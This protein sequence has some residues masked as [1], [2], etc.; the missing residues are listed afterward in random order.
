MFTEQLGW[1][2]C[3]WLVPE[4]IHKLEVYCLHISLHIYVG[5]RLHFEG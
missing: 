4:K 2:K 5:T 1:F 3:A